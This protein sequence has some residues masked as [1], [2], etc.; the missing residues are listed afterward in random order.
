MPDCI[1]CEYMETVEKKT[2]HQRI[3]S[4][5]N[6]SASKSRI[7]IMRKGF[8]VLS[9]LSY[10]SICF[11]MEATGMNKKESLE[12]GC[13]QAAHWCSTAGKP[14]IR[15]GINMAQAQVTTQEELI[16]A[17]A[18]QDEVIWILNDIMVS[19]AFIV[20]YPLLLESEGKE[21]KRLN[22]EQGYRQNMFELREGSDMT[23]RNIILKGTE[24]GQSPLIIVSGGTLRLK[25]GSVLEVNAFPEGGLA[26]CR[27]RSDVLREGST[28]EDNGGGVALLSGSRMIHTG[29]DIYDNEAQG[30]GGGVYVDTDS[31]YI[32]TG[33]G[34]VGAGGFNTAGRGPGV[35]NEGRIEVNGYRPLENGL[36]ISQRSAVARITGPLLPDSLI[37]LNETDYVAPD[38]SAA[39]IVVA[40]AT[41][42]YPVLTQTDAD[43]FH[44]PV[45]GFENWVIRLSDDGQRVELVL[46]M[47]TLTYRGNDEGGPAAQLVPDPR[48]IPQDQTAVLSEAI[49]VREGYDF[50]EWNT[51]PDGSGTAYQPGAEIGP[52]FSD[53]NLYA[54]WK[55]SMYDIIYHGNDE[56]GSR[57]CC[58]P[59]PQTVEDGRIITLS[60]TIPR[61][62]GYCFVNWNTR[63]DGSGASYC[64]CQR[65][66]PVKG[67][68]SLYAQWTQKR[69]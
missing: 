35:Y 1:Y 64:H 24:P 38:P 31:T 34:T 55:I 65:L 14:A 67:N 32:Q 9:A 43:A 41:E 17:L 60:G 48:Q 28:T 5:C 10:I 46:I 66:G 23:L 15:G 21:A 69:C 4:S 20:D 11:K 36:G 30:S 59:C 13:F 12:K 6:V 68:V 37:L 47:Y 8:T 42:E 45:S 16:A 22:T 57:A 29:G 44:K 40:E 27:N 50:L 26:A 3:I 33:N 49:P 51:L 52:V 58:I 39:P 53:I 7:V 19:E 18:R 61:R 62:P 56:G 54:Q 2:D 63:P 25:Q